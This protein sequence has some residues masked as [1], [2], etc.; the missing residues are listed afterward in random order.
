[1][2]Q[3]GKQF[4]DSDDTPL[5]HLYRNRVQ[6]PRS[7][8]LPAQIIRDDIMF[9]PRTERKVLREA[10]N[11]KRVATLQLNRQQ[12]ITK[13]VLDIANTREEKINAFERALDTLHNSSCSLGE[14]L[15]YVF[16]PENKSSRDWCWQ[17]FFKNKPLVQKILTYWTASTSSISARAFLKEWAVEQAG[18]AVADEAKGI[19]KD[20][21]LSKSNKAIDEHF[22]LDYSLL[23]LTQYLKTLAPMFFSI[24][25]AFSITNRQKSQLTDKWKETKMMVR[26]QLTSSMSS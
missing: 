23:T 6:R 19:C 25:E 12:T 5:Q 4:P 16:N 18:K 2:Q 10:A 14:F 13:K 26:C 11:K 24:L 1:M 20:G 7:S 15:E 8:S 3:S 9:T 21:V 22:F 17:G